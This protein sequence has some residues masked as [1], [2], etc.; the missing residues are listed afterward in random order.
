[1]ATDLLV[2]SA[3]TFRLLFVLVILGHDRGD[4]YTWPSPSIPPQLGLRSSCAMP[5]RRMKRRDI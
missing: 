1:M 3:I 2:V 4:S 5:F